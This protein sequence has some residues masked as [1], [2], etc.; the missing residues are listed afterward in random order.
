MDYGWRSTC[1][2]FFNVFLFYL[3]DGMSVVS[4]FWFFFSSVIKI[5]F[6]IIY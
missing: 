6:Y 3:L 1:D 2:I 5:I 4:L